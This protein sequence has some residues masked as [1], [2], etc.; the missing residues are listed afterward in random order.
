MSASRLLFAASV[1][2]A[3]LSSSLAGFSPASPKRHTFISPT[4][5]TRWSSALWLPALR[6]SSSYALHALSTRSGAV[7]ARLKMFIAQREVAGPAGEEDNF[8]KE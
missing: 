5:F 2:S 3:L 6:L 7:R 1:A 8:S 4:Y